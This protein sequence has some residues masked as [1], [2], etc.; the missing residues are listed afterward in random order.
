MWMQNKK[1]KNV[2]RR[3][4][5]AKFFW[6]GKKYKRGKNVDNAFIKQSS[7]A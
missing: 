2:K 1:I 7:L 6:M 4:R 3:M 5:F